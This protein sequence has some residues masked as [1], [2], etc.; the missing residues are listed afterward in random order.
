MA[1]ARAKTGDKPG[2]S[3]G[4]GASARRA[5]KAGQQGKTKPPPPPQQ[6]P[7]PPPPPPQQQQGARQQQPGAAPHGT[8]A[9]SSHGP[10]NG[11]TAPSQVQQQG[12]GEA[13]SEDHVRQAGDHAVRE[14]Q[15]L[16]VLPP[17]VSRLQAA[18][19]EG[20]DAAASGLAAAGQAAEHADGTTTVVLAGEGVGPLQQ[21]SRRTQ[22]P[23]P[24]ECD[25]PVAGHAE[26]LAPGCIALEPPGGPP[27]SPRPLGVA[28]P[29]SLPVASH[30]IAAEA[31]SVELA[32]AGP[33]S[34][35]PAP[36]AAEAGG[37]AL[38]A[39]GIVATAP[40]GRPAQLS[41]AAAATPAAAAAAAAPAERARAQPQEAVRPSEQQ[42]DEDEC[43]MCLDAPRGTTLAPCGHR[44]LCLPCTLALL[45]GAASQS[46][47]LCPVCRTGVASYILKEYRYT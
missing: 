6:Q 17:S 9:D 15:A 24:L 37:S 38:A 46:P 47:A 36:A 33:G 41:Q 12:R 16:S 23:P 10:A 35:A 45:D 20:S 31:G 18:A 30:I 3:P 11:G 1:A 29:P 44:V 42:E 4:K 22:L 32:I 7:L 39:A 27:A 28:L 43:L 25:G 5:G 8:D 26:H 2:S 14:V 34:A 19:P 40:L 13:S 21:T